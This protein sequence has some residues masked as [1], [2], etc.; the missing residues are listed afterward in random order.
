MTLSTKS[1]MDHL[2]YKNELANAEKITQEGK[3][4]I[5]THVLHKLI[6]CG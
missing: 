2:L 5:I 3:C 6:L 4:I 1:A